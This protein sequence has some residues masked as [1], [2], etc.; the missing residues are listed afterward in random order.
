MIKVEDSTHRLRFDMS[1][2][3][4]AAKLR[5]NRFVSMHVNAVTAT[6]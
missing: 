2:V 4:V 5:A 1:A 3:S 6:S